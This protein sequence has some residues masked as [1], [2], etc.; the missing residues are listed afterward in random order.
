MTEVDGVLYQLTETQVN[1]F[2]TAF[3]L[4]DK[5]QDGKISFSDFGKLF[6]SVGQNPSEEA[7]R[8]LIQIYDG[9]KGKGQ[10]SFTEFLKI[11]E[12]PHFQDPM[13]EEKVLESFR[14]FDR[15]AAGTITILE[16]R[17]ILQQLGERLTDEEADEFIEWAQKAQEVLV[18][19]GVLNYEQL[20]KE[21]MDK[22][23]N[24][25]S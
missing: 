13:K 23:P 14:E 9:Q 11:C 7:L 2:K 3:T 24:I 25:L 18:E 1:T 17:Y 8:Q 16:L 6:R 4:F 22:D 15:D 5:D 12:S 21:L 20:T 19:D 10:F